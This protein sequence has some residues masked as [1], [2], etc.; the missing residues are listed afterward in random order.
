MNDRDL[1]PERLAARHL[2]EE[3]PGLTAASAD[4]LRAGLAARVDTLR[5]AALAASRAGV[6]RS[7]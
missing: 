1:L 7:S 6:P 4:A 3:A 2:A 5:H